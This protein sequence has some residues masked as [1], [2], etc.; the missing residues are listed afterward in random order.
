M[1]VIVY[2]LGFG[3]IAICSC[4]I[5]Y[6]RASVDALNQLFRKYPLKYPAAVMALIGLLFFVSASATSHPWVLRIVGLLAIGEGVLA[7]TDPQKI[8][9]RCLDW[10]FE[11]VS[12]QGQRLFGIIGVIFGT[13]V[14]SWI[15]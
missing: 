7:F 12:D 15:V 5:L 10:Y 11:K 9:T 2:L 4:L 3:Y 8:Y 13:V 1:K 6:T 14:V